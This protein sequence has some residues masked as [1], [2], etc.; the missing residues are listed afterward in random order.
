[1]VEDVSN[2]AGMASHHR[3]EARALETEAKT[4]H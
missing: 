1:M 2:K 3:D 4:A